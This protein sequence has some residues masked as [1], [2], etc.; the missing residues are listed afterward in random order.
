M[1]ELSNC[2]SA[3]IIDET[4]ICSKCKEHC[5]PMQKE[6][7]GYIL[8]KDCPNIGK[9]IGDY[10]NNEYAESIEELIKKG[11]IEEEVLEDPT[12]KEP[13]WKEKLRH[14]IYMHCKNCSFTELD[15]EQFI[16]SL[17]SQKDKEVDISRRTIGYLEH[18][19]KTP[20]SWKILFG[21]MERVL[22]QHK[23]AIKALLKPTK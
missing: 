14:M 16:S 8:K 13:E 9:E 7:K 20:L 4:D 11:V 15:I 18:I 1:I 21:R 5:E 10:Y 2:C 19:L 6:E 23:Q 3:K 22:E 17:L 12:P